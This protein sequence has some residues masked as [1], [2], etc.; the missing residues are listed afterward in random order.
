MPDRLDSMPA[1]ISAVFALT[2]AE[3]RIMRPRS[4]I[5]ISRKTGSTTA[6][7]RAS[8]QEMKNMATRAPPMVTKLM[9]RFSG[10]WCASSVTSNRSEVRRLMSW[11]VRLE[12]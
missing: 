11:P 1:L 3:A 10:P 9:S 7:T 8:C 5:R 6:T 4:S 12:S 2:A